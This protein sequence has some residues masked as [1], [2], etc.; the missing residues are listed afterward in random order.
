MLDGV[1]TGLDSQLCGKVAVRVC[2]DLA[3]P[4]VG[5]RDDGGQLVRGELRDVDGIGFGENAP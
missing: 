4:P 2:R 1:D 3:L 5:F